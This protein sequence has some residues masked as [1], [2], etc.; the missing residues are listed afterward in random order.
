SLYKNGSY[1]D[2]KIVCGTDTYNVHKAIICPQS[3]FFRA[4]C[5]PYPFQEGKTGVVTLPCNPGRDLDALAAPIKPDDFDWD[6]DVEDKSAVKLMVHYF[7]HHDYPSEF[8]TY[9]GHDSLT[10]KT[11]TKGVLAVHAKMFAMG[12]KYEVR[13]LK[14]VALEKYQ[15]CLPETCAGFGTSIIIAFMGT[16]ETEIDLGLRSAI[17]D[18]LSDSD[19]MVE[20]EALEKTIEEIPELVYALYRR[21]LE[22]SRYW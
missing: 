22:R 1:S 17:V 12:E 20:H 15:A 5:R 19:W 3:E 21:L 18:S 10:P 16:T 11:A 4:A 2:F 13:G 9:E 7:Y 8:P 6:M 14:S